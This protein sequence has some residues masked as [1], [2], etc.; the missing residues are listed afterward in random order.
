MID[1]CKKN[2]P[3][4]QKELYELYAGKLYGVCLSYCADE[5]DASDT[6]HD[7]FMK[8]FGNIQ[9]YKGDGSFEGWMRRIMVNTALE[10]YRRVKRME[11]IAADIRA[12]SERSIDH[13]M[14]DLSASEI[15]EIDHR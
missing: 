8:I 10:R 9:Q 2:H 12:T 11:S 14:D 1:G 3:L 13:I 7:G 5:A 6:L 15:M 4:A